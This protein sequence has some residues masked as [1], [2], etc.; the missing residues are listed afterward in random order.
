MQAQETYLYGQCVAKHFLFSQLSTIT[1]WYFV[2]CAYKFGCDEYLSFISFTRSDNTLDKIFTTMSI[3]DKVKVLWKTNCEWRDKPHWPKRKE[4][5]LREGETEGELLSLNPGDAVK[6][7]FGS[8]WYDAEIAESW[9]P[10]S[11]KGSY[12]YIL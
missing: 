1:Q 2:S 8:R 4:I 6:I 7:K 3:N 12:C 5:K 11:K 10:K 9:T